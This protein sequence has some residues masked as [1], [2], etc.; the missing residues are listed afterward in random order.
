M[1]YFSTISLC[2]IVA[3]CSS[4]TSDRIAYQESPDERMTRIVSAGRQACEEKFPTSPRHKHLAQARCVV[5]FKERVVMPQVDYP[6][7][8]ARQNATSLAIAEK[9][10]KGTISDAEAN[11]Q[12]ADART[13]AISEQLKRKADGAQT[14]AQIASAQAAQSQATTAAM[15]AP[16]PFAVPAPDPCPVLVG[17]RC[18]KHP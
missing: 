12:I 2:I 3:G 8:V 11:Q 16:N 15:S 6:D 18:S 5:E 14:Q 4:G 13:S 1:R 10:D 7:L 9:Q 17:G